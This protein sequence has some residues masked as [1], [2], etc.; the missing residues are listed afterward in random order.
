MSTNTTRMTIGM[1]SSLVVQGVAVL[2]GALMP[3]VSNGQ[4]PAPILRQQHA[5]NIQQVQVTTDP[6]RPLDRRIEAMP[7]SNQKMEVIQNRSQLVIT[8]RKI[9][10]MA[11]S[12]PAILDIV[13]FTETEISILGLAL[14]TTDLW[15][16]FED[17]AD[18]LMYEVAVIPDPSLDEQRRLDYGRIERKISLLYPNSKVY[19]IPMTYRII[20]RGQAKD[21]EEAARIMQLVRTEVIAQESRFGGLGGQFGGLGGLGGRGA[22]GGGGGGL[23]DFD[24]NFNNN[25]NGLNDFIVD[26]LQVPGEFQVMIRVR[27]AELNRSQARR[28]GI[29]ISGIINDSI[30]LGS[31]LIAAGAGTLTGIYEGGEIDVA[32]DALATNGT[33]KILEDAQLVTLSG[34][35][36]AFLSGGE[37]AVPTVVG[38]GGAQGQTT[39]FRGFGTSIIATPTVVDDDLIRLQIV[40]ELSGL[41]GG[42]VGGIPN[43]DVRRVQTRVELREGQTI[44]LGGLFSRRQATEVSRIPFLGEIPVIG[45]FLFHAKQATED[46]NELLIIV[47]PEIVRPMDADQVPPLPGWYV[48]HPD[49]IDFYKYNRTEGNPD[50]GHYHLLPY[51][52][53]HGVGDDVGYN[54]YNPQPANGLEPGT[55]QGQ[56]GQLMQPQYQQQYQPQYQQP[57]YQPVQPQYQNGPTYQPQPTPAAPVGQVSYQRA[58]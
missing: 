12:D 42:N 52:N 24:N 4:T 13:Q 32:I 36:A 23:G 8:K 21:S 7:R 9:R 50:M 35:P 57:Q 38:I 48:T 46:E 41:S 55:Y 28:M 47:T 20:V 58:R 39:T 26:E 29:N 44:V 33:A 40:P 19:L 1:R 51:G 37:F 53:G 10:R 54:F 27:I 5:G 30:S 56:Q 31:Q 18:P 43:V 6:R 11:W 17:Q 34:E 45:N 22:R 16:W 25:N 15:L 14:G 3:A 49:D 2:L